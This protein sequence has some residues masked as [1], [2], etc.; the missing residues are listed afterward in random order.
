MKIVLKVLAIMMIFILP[1][2]LVGCENNYPDS[3]W[4]PKA[5]S[6]PQPV[7]EQ[8]IPA[9]SA[10]AGVG[11]IVI[12]G[13][14]FS[15]K[16]EEN[17]VFFSGH[18]AET[19]TATTTEL[20][21]QSP[22]IVG[23]DLEVK[24]AVHGA[25]LFSKPM[26]YKLKAAVQE[27][28]KFLESEMVEVVATDVAGNVY[29]NIEGK[30]I[31][32]IAPDGETTHFADVSFLK[33]NGMK[34]G[35]GNTLYVV[36]AAGRVKKIATISPDG[37]EGTFTTMTKIPRDLDFDVN[38]NIWVTG[39]KDIYLVKPDKSKT[40]I[41]SFPL[42]LEVVRVFDGHLYIYGRD[43]ASGEAKIWR[44]AIQGETL[45]AEELV[46]DVAAATWLEGATVFTFTFSA[47]GEM[48]LGT[49]HPNN[50]IFIY[51][52][53]DGSDSIL[54]PGLIGPKINSLNWDN[55]PYLY[56]VQ[57]LEGTSNVLK[58]DLGKQGAP[59]FGRK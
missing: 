18:R 47:D 33:A 10:Y 26:K 29:A 53:A 39:D 51:N 30:V 59:Y 21:V 45:G 4:N 14:N 42:I 6:S 9:D 32:K 31:K 56:A 46:L 37:T 50:A 34:M 11:T 58:I 7:I 3:I 23:S 35:P 24:V 25:E 43:D 19:V 5:A 41:K 12:K 8:I 16:P 44:C 1:V 28:G 55:G 13:K 40:K 54:F 36:F 17:L 49:D 20:T 15:S 52:M 2:F 57:Q 48:Y 27:V 22:N 38:E